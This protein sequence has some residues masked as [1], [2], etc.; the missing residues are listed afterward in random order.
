M[1]NSEE[2]AQDLLQEVFV[3]IWRKMDLYDT[4]KGK[5]FTWIINIARN[6]AID[7]LRSEEYRK[8]NQ[9][10]NID[11]SVGML[12][13]SQN[14]YSKVDQI[15]LKESVS[16]LRAEYSMVLELL[17]YKGYTQDEVAKELSIP[18]GTVKTR[19]RA[20]VMQLREM[21]NVTRNE[22]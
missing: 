14:T 17:Y 12:N 15:G 20:A 13:P 19:A 8:Q 4:G 9:N 3:K 22:Q 1:V 5:L 6:T 10:L 7:M 21:M 11:D 18:L 2:I 16:S